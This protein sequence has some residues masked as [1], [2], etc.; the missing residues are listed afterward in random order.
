M[1]VCVRAHKCYAFIFFHLLYF[2]STFCSSLLII[3]NV[4]MYAITFLKWFPHNLFTLG[5]TFFLSVCPQGIRWMPKSL[6]CQ[7][8]WVPAKTAAVTIRQVSAPHAEPFSFQKHLCCNKISVFSVINWRFLVFMFKNLFFFKCF[9]CFVF[10][11]NSLDVWLMNF[12]TSNKHMI[13]FTAFSFSL[14]NLYWE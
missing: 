9:S 1:C 8:R 7:T 10:F 13:H 6:T 4:K 2:R 11:K 12:H 3:W 5:P 14:L